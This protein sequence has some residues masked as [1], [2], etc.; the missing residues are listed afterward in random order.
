[1]HLPLLVQIII[2]IGRSQFAGP[3]PGGDFG[4]ALPDGQKPFLTL[5]GGRLKNNNQRHGT[6]TAG[7]AVGGGVLPHGQQKNSE[8]GMHGDQEHMGSTPF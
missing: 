2:I 8:H 6:V 7:C 4:A 1:M 3:G 5:P